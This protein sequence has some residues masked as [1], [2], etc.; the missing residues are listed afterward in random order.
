MRAHRAFRQVALLLNRRG[1]PVF[2][3]DY[4]ATG[5]SAGDAEEAALDRWVN[6]VGWAIEEAQRRSGQSRVRLAGLRLGATLAALATEGRSDVERLVFWDAV[7][8]GESFVEELCRDASPRV[9]STWW[10][11]GFPMPH[12]LRKALASV[13]LRKVRFPDDAMIVQMISHSSA[14]FDTL[15]ETL[16]DHPGSAETRLVPSPSDWNYSDDV[17]G[18]LIPREMVRGVVGA[19]A[20]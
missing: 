7:V 10:V 6:D 2:R 11:H 9:G 20:D 13:D 8:R 17:G 4:W 19:L 14:D 18:I 12:G 16:T 3:F 5:D 15:T 1:L